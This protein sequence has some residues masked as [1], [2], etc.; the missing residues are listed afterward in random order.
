MTSN[1]RKKQ[2]AWQVSNGSDEKKRRAAAQELRRIG[3]H[4]RRLKG[5]K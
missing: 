3:E 4:E 2:L 5:G 1:A